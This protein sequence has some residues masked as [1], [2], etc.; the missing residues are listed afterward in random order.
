MQCFKREEFSMVSFQR[1]WI[2][3]CRLLSKLWQ[4]RANFRDNERLDV[5]QNVIQVW[6]LSC[7]SVETEPGAVVL[8]SRQKCKEADC[9]VRAH[10]S[11]LWIRHAK[12]WTNAL[13]LYKYWKCGKK[14]H[15]GGFLWGNR[16]DMSVIAQ[17]ANSSSSCWTFQAV[18]RLRKP[19]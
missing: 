7:S 9:L 15:S 10:P 16:L 1:P 4:K 13:N 18:T 17:E 12:T 6:K 14:T 3:E 5:E 19:C 11:K 8:V 2:S